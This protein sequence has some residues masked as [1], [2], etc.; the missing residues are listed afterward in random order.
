MLDHA[1]T[2]SGKR[3]VVT[4]LAIARTKMVN[5]VTEMTDQWLEHMFFE[6]E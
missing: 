1:P 2:D 5:V 3:Y 6:S 4:C